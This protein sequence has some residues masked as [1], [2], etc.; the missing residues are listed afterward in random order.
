MA[1]VVA[2]FK[3]G[4]G[5]LAHA[6]QWDGDLIDTWANIHAWT[7]RANI[8]HRGV[9]AI[10]TGAI[11][12]NVGVGDWMVMDSSKNPQVFSMTDPQ[13]QSTYTATTP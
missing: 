2:D 8:N 7:K 1:N 4:L 10:Q 5:N 6:I 11:N 9:L 12:L 13:F 3:D